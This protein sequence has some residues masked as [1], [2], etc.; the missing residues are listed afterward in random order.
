VTTLAQALEQARGA[1]VH[2][3]Q[4]RLEAEVLLAHVLNKPRSHLHAWP[5][6]QLGADQQALFEE[7]VRRR[8]TGEP[9]AYLTG[10][11]EFW[12]LEFEVS[13]ATLIPRPE[14]ELLVEQALELLPAKST[15]SV[16]DLGTG[17]GAVAIALARE[18]PR[19]QLF[20]SDRSSATVEVARCN[21]RRLAGHNLHLLIGD[22]T[23]AFADASVDAIV[24]NP[25][26]V[27]EGDPHLLLDDARHEPRAA[28]AAGPA[29]L[30][31][32]T[33]VAG[34]AL[35]VLKPGGWLCLEH[36][37]AQAAA[38][39]DFLS[40]QCFYQVTTLRDLAG[41]ERVTR[42]RKPL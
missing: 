2:H 40:G 21:A 9:V 26:Y 32:L 10:R 13:R 35:R 24:S 31:D 36:A 15:L 12:S 1:L 18:R 19:W 34:D 38:L 17:S 6:A 25:P 16:A 4:A 5:E 20:A 29:G 37:P 7:L 22:W 8:A 42:A 33:R 28:L 11:R 14:T 41:L 3:E 27:A 30:D 23:G 39:G